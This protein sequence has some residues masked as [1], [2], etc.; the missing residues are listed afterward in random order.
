MAK[1]TVQMIK[2]LL[3]FSSVQSL[4][5]VWLFVTPW[6]TAHQ[7]SLSITSSRSLLKHIS[8]ELVMPSNHLI[9]CCPLLLLPSIFPSIRLFSKES[10]LH[11]RWP[12]YWSFSF[13]ISPSNEHPGLISFRMDKLDLLAVQGTLKSLLQHHSYLASKVLKCHFCHSR[14]SLTPNKFNWSGCGIYLY[15]SL[16]K[17]ELM[18]PFWRLSTTPF[19]RILWW[20]NIFIIC[21]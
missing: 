18:V 11:I 16:E 21:W 6:T 8:I 4:S 9:L 7:A 1:L 10:V 12:K 13:N 14:Q 15:I 5:C 2:L 19:H 20:Y 3:Q 17:K